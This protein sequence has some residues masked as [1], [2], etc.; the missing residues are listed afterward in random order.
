MLAPTGG[1]I[2]GQRTEKRQ[3]DQEKATAEPKGEKGSKK[4]KT[5]QQE[6]MPVNL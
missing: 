6:L 1:I 4:G 3:R 5:K 2:Y